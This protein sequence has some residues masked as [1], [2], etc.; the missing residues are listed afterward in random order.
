MTD[1]E[2]VMW[3]A[4][5][6]PR[7]PPTRGLLQIL[8]CEPDWNPPLT[9]RAGRPGASDAQPDVAAGHPAAPPHGRSSGPPGAA[10]PR[11]GPA[12][13]AD[14]HA[15]RGGDVRYG[16]L[17]PLPAAGALPSPRRPFPAPG[18]PR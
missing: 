8:G 13:P 6:E 16:P 10:V 17:H 11:V 14:R 12:R 9:H 2:A 1:W 5:V 4:E 18:R 15:P 7:T 3:R